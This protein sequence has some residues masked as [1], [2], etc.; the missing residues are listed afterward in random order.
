MCLLLG[1]CSTTEN[2]E[3]SCKNRIRN[4]PILFSGGCLVDDTDQDG[5]PDDQDL[6]AYSSSAVCSG[7]GLNEITDERE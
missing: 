4:N 2:Y 6:C 7:T 3:V 1:A 5:V